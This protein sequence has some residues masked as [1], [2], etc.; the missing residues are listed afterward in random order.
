M[1][2]LFG[3]YRPGRSRLH[4][5]PAGTKLLGLAVASV[6]VVALPGP[7]WALGVLGATLAL[8]AYAGMG[9]RLLTGTL[10][11][12]LVLVVL[13]G[14]WLAW[15]RGWSTA[16]EAVANLV[17]LV[18]LS[19][20]LTVT[21][22]VDQILDAVARGL[23]PLRRVGV[24]PESVALAFALLIRAL[25]TTISIAEETRDAARARG[26]DRDPRARLIP[27]VIRV[28]AHARATGDALHARGVLD[29]P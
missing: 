20:V 26:L 28:V 10:R 13:L 7:W 19:T 3:Q 15:Q 24:R 17:A 2:E 8:S 6:V 14:G 22:P 5:L 21:T 27:L 25:P 18:L 16:I 12:L 23:R 1:V 4:R 11:G 29:D 9:V